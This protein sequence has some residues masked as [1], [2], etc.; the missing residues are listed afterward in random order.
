M[1]PCGDCRLCCKV[2]P[3]LVLDKPAGVWCHHAC[4]A[5]CAIHGPRTPEICR[6][7]D[8]YWREHD[9]LSESWRPDRIGI[10]VTE[11]GN[12]TAGQHHLPVV[13]FQEDSVEASR[14]DAARGLLDHFV[15]RGFSVMG[16]HGLGAQIEFDRARW[17]GISTDDIEAA[18]RYEL[19]QDAENLKR[20][21]A[22]GNEYR[23]LS[24]DEAE[25]ACR[26][27]RAIARNRQGET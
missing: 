17:P 20:L 26:E 16:I 18:L 25:S 27:E 2:F 15:S 1:R 12:V 19:S 14:G 22:V 4:A 23:P 9:V 7:Y 6:Q 8:C 21:G 11:A 5:G 13:L 10:V 3:V 24:R